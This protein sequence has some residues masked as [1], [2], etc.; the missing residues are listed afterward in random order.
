ML[1]SVHFRG[2]GASNQLNRQGVKAQLA[3]P[4]QRRLIPQN[5]GVAAAISGSP[6]PQALKAT[7]KVPN[8]RSAFGIRTMTGFA[9]FW[10]LTYWSS[11]SF[12]P[13][14]RLMG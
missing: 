7:P 12:R 8:V 14:S 5:L 10:H 11:V 9:L 1:S 3:D 2:R 4:A 6:R 13:N